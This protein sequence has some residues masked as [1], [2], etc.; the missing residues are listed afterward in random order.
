LGGFHTHEHNINHAHSVGVVGGVHGGQRQVAV[1]AF[2]DQP[3]RFKGGQRGPAREKDDVMTGLLQT[4]AEHTTDGA[5]A[6]HGNAKPVER[7]RYRVG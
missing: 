5:G 3:A 4:G 6:D 1:D 2:E 7:S